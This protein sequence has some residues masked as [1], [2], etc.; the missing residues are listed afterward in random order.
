MS[1]YQL[2]VEIDKEML[3]EKGNNSASIHERFEGGC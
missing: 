2:S 1:G 3:A